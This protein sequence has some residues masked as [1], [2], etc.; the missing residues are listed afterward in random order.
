MDRHRPATLL[1]TVP[2][3]DD[4]QRRLRAALRARD[5]DAAVAAAQTT[6]GGLDLLDALDLVMLLGEQHDPRF[7][8]WARRWIDRL[9]AEHQLQPDAVASVVKLMREVP[10][11][12]EARAIT[13]ALRSWARPPRT[14]G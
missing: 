3:Q 9:A 10:D 8:R 13:V 7:D 6:P 11:Q 12:N 14:W 1:G 2:D 5:V 4:H